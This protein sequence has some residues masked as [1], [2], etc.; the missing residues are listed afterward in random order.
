MQALAADLAGKLAMPVMDAT[1]LEGGYDY[2]LIFNSEVTS[3][4]EVG[5]GLP[6]EYPFLRDALRQQLGL[7][8]MPVKDV[9]IDVVIIDSANKK[10]TEN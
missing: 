6:S 4:P 8:L 1:G 5:E 10:P 7:E 2:T 9:P 3:G